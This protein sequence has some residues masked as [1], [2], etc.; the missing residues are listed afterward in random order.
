MVEHAEVDLGL[1]FHPAIQRE[2]LVVKEL[3]R[4]PLQL[5]VPYGHAFL[6]EDPATL[7]LERVLHEPLVL[8]RSTSRLRRVI[9]QALARYGF[10]WQPAVEIDSVAGLKELVRQG[11]GITLLPA[12]LLGDP[13]GSEQM[14]LIPLTE[15]TEQFSFALVYRATG[16]ISAPARQFIN[17]LLASGGL[18]KEPNPP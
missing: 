5:L 8:P 1:I 6:H 18:G 17:L 2:V 4:Q 11:C 10:S 14:A 16:P 9:D 13:P 15:L 12:A 7:S 3:F